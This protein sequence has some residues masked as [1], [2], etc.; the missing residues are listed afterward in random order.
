MGKYDAD[1]Q[2]ICKEMQS[3]EEA[4]I[5]TG[6]SPEQWELIRKYIISALDLNTHAMANS[7][8]L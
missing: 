8:L 3:T 4:L 7:N 5:A 6:F 1:I 2:R